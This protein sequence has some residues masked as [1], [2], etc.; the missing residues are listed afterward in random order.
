MKIV[1]Y[2]LQV[3]VICIILW[4]LCAV[5]LQQCLSTDSSSVSKAG[6]V[7]A[8]TEDEKGEGKAKDSY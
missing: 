2:R 4:T 8:H 1:F 6:K 3:T 5:V 7:V